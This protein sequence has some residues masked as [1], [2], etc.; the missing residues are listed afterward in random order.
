MR[1][2]FCP[3]EFQNDKEFLLEALARRSDL[4]LEMNRTTQQECDVAYA[5][6]VSESSTPAVHTRVSNHAPE[7][8]SRREVALAIV[9]RGNEQFMKK[10]I[11]EQGSE[12]LTDDREIML[13]AIQ[14]DA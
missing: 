7:L 6:I 1:F 13:T 5:A 2:R 14:R 12:R 4:Y 10:F 11:A 3:F 9:Q 8:S